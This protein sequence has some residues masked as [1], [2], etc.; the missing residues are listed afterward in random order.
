MWLNGKQ[1]CEGKKKT[2]KIM[3]DNAFG[4]QARHAEYATFAT[5]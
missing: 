1:G 5:S 3:H 4:T 2:G